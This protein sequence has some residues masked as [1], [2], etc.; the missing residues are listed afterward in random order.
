M[1]IPNC[2]A[3]LPQMSANERILSHSTAH[4]E[5]KWSSFLFRTFAHM[6][7]VRHRNQTHLR[8]KCALEF[9][10]ILSFA[11]I[12]V[13]NAGKF[14]VCNLNAHASNILCLTALVMRQMFTQES[15][16]FAVVKSAQNAL[17]QH[18]FA[19]ICAHWRPL[20]GALKILSAFLVGA[21]IGWVSH[22][23]G[24]ECY[25]S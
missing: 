10:K 18:S 1:R 22:I 8:S 4:F 17:Y 2:P 14:G 7:N 3:F 16:S 9:L 6:A 11:L 15:T 21:K 23:N 13:K 25:I 5:R 12:C 20:L 19:L 24:T